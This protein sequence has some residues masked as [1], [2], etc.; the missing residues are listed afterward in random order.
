MMIV[1]VGHLQQALTALTDVAREWQ[2]GSNLGI[3]QSAPTY[4]HQ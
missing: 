3:Q 2:L 4:I 1:V